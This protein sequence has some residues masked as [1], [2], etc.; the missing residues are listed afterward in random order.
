M[1]PAKI[2][3]CL[4]GILLILI[5]VMFLSFD[6][7]DSETTEGKVDFT[8][9]TV[10]YN[11]DRSPKNIV[12][13]WVEDISGKFVKTLLLR[14]DRRKEW[15]LTWNTKSGGSTVDAITGATLNSHQSHTVA[16]D[17]TDVSGST[18]E[19]GDY[20]IVVEFTEEHAQGPLT[21]VSFTKG[22]ENT[23]ITPADETNFISMNLQYTV[24][25]S[26]DAAGIPVA[27]TGVISVYPTISKDYFTI[28][29]AA[30]QST[31]SVYD[32]TGNLVLK[33]VT[34]ET[35]TLV[36]A[37]GPGTYFIRVENNGTVETFRIIQAK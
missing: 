14:A 12:A 26:V 6:T 35:E 10:T 31:I 4:R 29:T 33:A 36:S 3:Y 13:I 2:K 28:R 23:T 37:P 9:K 15:L 7:A 27:E 24:N 8:V 34:Q 19:D 21:S 20:K 22:S 30:G 5:P 16:W 17:C 11:G 1:I 18:V 32:L 25:F